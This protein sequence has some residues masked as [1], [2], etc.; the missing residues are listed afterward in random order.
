MQ[1]DHSLILFLIVNN[2]YMIINWLFSKCRRA[3]EDIVSFHK[4]GCRFYSYKVKKKLKLAD[5]GA[6]E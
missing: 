4:L 1:F 5:L 6:S 3:F 2:I